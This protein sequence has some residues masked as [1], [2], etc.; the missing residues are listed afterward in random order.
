MS[1]TTVGRL[2]R[3]NK[4]VWVNCGIC[5]HGHQVDLRALAD[6]IGEDHPAMHEDLERLFFCQRCRDRG[7]KRR[8]IFFTV[9]P[10]YGRWAGRIN[11][12]GPADPLDD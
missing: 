6:R 3:E 2:I 10:D 12:D 1:K 11:H 9:I 4:T 7:D 5:S 8:S